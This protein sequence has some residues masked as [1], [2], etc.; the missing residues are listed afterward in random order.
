MYLFYDY[1]QIGILY[2]D[3]FTFLA[4]YG[5]LILYA[6]N[7]MY[8]I[9]LQGG[10][11]QLNYISSRQLCKQE[12][13]LSCISSVN[14]GTSLKQKVVCQYKTTSCYIQIFNLV[15]KS[16]QVLNY[17]VIHLCDELGTHPRQEIICVFF[18]GKVRQL[19]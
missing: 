13:Y 12:R 15:F 17:I 19:N 5:N 11:K 3:D 8:L 7:K 9:P 6:C 16:E 1:I 14:S 18:V 10:I 4:F 2:Q